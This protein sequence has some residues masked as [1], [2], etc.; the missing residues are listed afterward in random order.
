MRQGSAVVFFSFS[1][2]FFLTAQLLEMSAAVSPSI[3]T[4]A[5]PDHVN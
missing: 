3:T 4:E 1:F 5:P 2:F